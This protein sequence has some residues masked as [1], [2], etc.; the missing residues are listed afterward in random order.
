M[1]WLSRSAGSCGIPIVASDVK[2][3]REVVTED[4][5]FLCDPKDPTPYAEALAGLIDDASL[6]ER[7][8]TAARRRAE[9]EFDVHQTMT[10]IADL[11]ALLMGGTEEK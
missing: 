10:K 8:S 2:G 11:Y 5:G 3:N 7:F 9:T 6:R 4:T 1:R